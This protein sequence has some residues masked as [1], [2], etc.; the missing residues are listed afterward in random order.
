MTEREHQK[1]VEA[2]KNWWYCDNII[3]EHHE[4]Q[5]ALLKMDFPQCFILIRD[6]AA[7][8]YANWAEFKE[9]AEV[10]F[11]N[12]SDRQKADLERILVDAY[13][14]MRLQEEENERQAILGQ[15]EDIMEEDGF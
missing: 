14:F 11:F 13:N 2:T 1:F 7:G 8:M 4:G 15:M 6:D 10:N 5:F 12:P 9:I 3:H